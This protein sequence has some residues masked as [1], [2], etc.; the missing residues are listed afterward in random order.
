MKHPSPWRLAPFL[1]LA[2]LLPA[3]AVTVNADFSRDV[4]NGPNPGTNPAPSLYAGT[5]PA[6]DGGT[7]WNDLA[8]PLQ[9]TGDG[10]TDTIAHPLQFDNLVASDGT[11]TSI[12]LQLTSGF[13][14]SFNG[15]PSGG[16]VSA[17]QDDRVFPTLGNLA[18]LKI[19]GLD[20][21]RK[22]S[23]FLIGSGGFSTAFTV[24]AVTKVAAGTPYD[25]AWS[26]GGEHVSFTGLSPNPAGEISIGIRDGTAPIDSFGV[27]SGI[28]IAE[29]P[30]NFLYPAGAATTG[31][32]FNASY[33]PSNL[34]NG[35]FTGPADTINTV[36]NYLAA[37]NNYATASG[38]TV[39]FDLTFDFDTPARIGAMHVW[40]YIFRNSATGG[41]ASAANGVNSYTL[42]FHDGPGATGAVIGPVHAGNLAPARFDALNS[43]QTVYFP[44]PYE[45]VRSVVM[46]VLTSHGG[47]TFTGLN[48]LAFDGSAGG[49]GPSIASFA[50]SAPFVQR[51][52]TPVLNWSV[53]G[54]ITSL[55]ISPGIGDV[56]ALTAGGTGSI[57]VSPLGEQTYTLTLNGT[58]QRSVSVVGLPPREKLH[59]YLLIGQSNMQGSGAPFSAALDAPDPRVIKFGSRNGMEKTW[60]KGSHNLTSLGTTNSGVGLGIEFGKAILAAQTDPEVVVGLVN[61]AIGSSA[62]Q[63]W[64]PGVVNNKQVNPVT[65]QNHRLYDEAVQRVADAS[66]H[67]VLKGVLWHQGEYN[68]GNNSDPDSDPAGYAARL[69]ALVSNLRASFGDPALPFV[70]GKF[71]PATWTYADGTPGAFNGL[72]F[73]A[74]VEAALADLPN[75]RTNTFCVDNAGLRGRSDELIHFDSYSQRLLGQR[76][77]A[78]IHGLRADP[79]LLYLG[80]FFTPAQ[81]ALPPYSDPNGD[82]DGDGL[83][84]LLEF[85]FGTDPS[86]PQAGSPVTLSTV[87]IPGEGDFPALTFRRRVDTEAP[88]YLVEVSDNL[89]TWTG[90]TEG[91]PPVAVTVGSPVVHGDGF[92]TITVRHVLP[93]SSAGS[94]FLRVRVTQP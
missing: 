36:A 49:A 28:Q 73:R 52:A 93:I 54:E 57:P 7:I 31:G 16:G 35:G 14:R 26:E 67:G 1:V 58:L 77:A 48:E 62:I 32:Q 61:H 11:P 79:H 86:K 9:A 13:F 24:D 39:N 66:E 59:L 25:G 37:N 19:L 74:T 65:G 38:T 76:Y 10:G 12:D 63:W 27:I 44:A 91:Q 15:A 17:L 5:G 21:A 45:N 18:T 90:N 60:V 3:H 2:A 55:A 70:C 42:T 43:A 4:A 92:E 50:A 33:P 94:S 22:Y 41:S 23:L 82:I 84:S 83:A 30:V 40:N 85:A 51:P 71:V 47:A 68:S 69:Q 6:P 88:A 64:A 20:P 80:G 87:A 53:T 29:I 75:R 78:A 72:P 34:M 89:N 56:T 46:R 8:I 81:L